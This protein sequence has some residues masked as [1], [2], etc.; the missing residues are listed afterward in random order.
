MILKIVQLPKNFQCLNIKETK[1]EVT[2][3]SY[4]EMELLTGGKVPL[5]KTGPAR[6]IS[7][8]KGT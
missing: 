5:F 4:E 3:G 2:E 6:P 1:D 8:L 7:L